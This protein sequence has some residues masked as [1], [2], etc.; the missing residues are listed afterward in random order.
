VRAN[1]VYRPPLHYRAPQLYFKRL[2]EPYTLRW[3]Y[4]RA[5][6]QYIVL[7]SS[8]DSDS[9]F[10]SLSPTV[11]A[12]DIWVLALETTPAGFDLTPLSDG[13]A[14]WEGSSGTQSWLNKLY[15]S[16]LGA[17]YATDEDGDYFS[18]I[19]NDQA[20]VET[21]PI[22]SQQAYT[23]VP[24]EGPILD[25]FVDEPEG[26]AITYDFALGDALPSG[27]SIETVVLNPG[28]PNERTVQQIGGTPALGQQGTYDIVMRAADPGGNQTTLTAW[29]L[30]VDVGVLVPTVDGGSLDWEGAG[31]E[32]ADAGL[33]VG[34]IVA[35]VNSATVGIVFDQ[36]PEGG[37]Y[38]IPASPVVL[39][40][41]G[42]EVPDV[43]G[44][45]R[46]NAESEITT[47]G[48]AVDVAYIRTLSYTADTVISQS[49]AAL[50][51]FPLA[52]TVVL[53]DQIVTLS[54]ARTPPISLVKTTTRKR[55]T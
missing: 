9:P 10:T 51:G 44:D 12:G 40:V 41:S 47:A 27:L 20:P 11:A 16:S 17:Y 39:Y 35:Q 29:S 31:E 38:A 24:Y 1:H 32:I 52:P 33:A 6:E 22:P 19:I 26:Q 13:T 43:V 23:G 37:T 3:L 25:D 55:F 18:I 28:E 5:T 53:P 21:A 36:E 45:P 48:L 42:I 34:D 8:L 2:I 14:S 30:T 15:D 4:D 50:S 7:G 46:A 54:V 49:P